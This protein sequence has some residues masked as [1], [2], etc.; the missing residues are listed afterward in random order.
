MPGQKTQRRQVTSGAS[1]AE[2]SLLPIPVT[3][4][5]NHQ[6]GHTATS[7]SSL[8]VG[9]WLGGLACLVRSRR[10]ACP[11][12]RT[13][14]PSRR[15]RTCTVSTHRTATSPFCGWSSTFD[16]SYPKFGGPNYSSY[17]K[18]KKKTSKKISGHACLNACSDRFQLPCPGHWHPAAARH[19]H[20]AHG[21]PAHTTTCTPSGTGAR[22]CPQCASVVPF[23]GA[24]TL[25]VAAGREAAGAR[26]EGEGGA[27]GGVQSSEPAAAGGTWR[28]RRR[29]ICC[30]C[31]NI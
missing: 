3:A 15:L 13:S 12:P 30:F 7:S 18:K 27:R 22:A 2:R 19:T 11:A 14:C 23:A 29:S 10:A 9:C 4:H 25:P 24:F 1:P 17:K 28:R 16:P 8:Q 20:Q 21:T 31:K 6:C 5:L 26:V